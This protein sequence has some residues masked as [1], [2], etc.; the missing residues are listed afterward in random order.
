MPRAQTLGSRSWQARSRTRGGLTYWPGVQQPLVGATQRLTSAGPSQRTLE[1][2]RG[3][4]PRVAVI[5]RPDAE[6]LGLG[7]GRGGTVTADKD[8]KRLVR[9]RAQRTGESYVTARRHLLRTGHEEVAMSEQ[10]VPVVFE[11]VRQTEVEERQQHVISL[12]ERGGER[13]LSIWIGPTEA[14]AIAMG[15]QS[16]ETPRPMTHDTLKRAVGAL[17]G[18]PSRVEIGSRPNPS[19]TTYTAELVIDREGADS[20]SFDCRPSDAIA[21]AVR[22]EP[23]LEIL[24]PE[25]LLDALGEPDGPGGEEA[26]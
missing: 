1:R 25:T 22:Y 4:N 26:P 18:R 3:A 8:F 15:A 10:L 17:G 5:N 21:L 14:A 7:S 12:C 6:L 24:V 16:V 13:R 19:V 20:V 23:P 9:E 11:H 2:Q